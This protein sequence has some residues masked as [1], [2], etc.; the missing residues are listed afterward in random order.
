[1]PLLVSNA[2]KASILSGSGRDMIRDLIVRV[3]RFLA[4]VTA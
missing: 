2:T 3:R 4:I 1:M